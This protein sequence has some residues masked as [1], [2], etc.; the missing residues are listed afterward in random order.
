MLSSLEENFSGKNV[1]GWVQDPLLVSK[2]HN[3]M[4]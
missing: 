3:G 1:F 4:R 2:H